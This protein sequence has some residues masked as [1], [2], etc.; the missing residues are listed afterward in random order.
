MLGFTRV[1]RSLALSESGVSHKPTTS[2]RALFLR[3]ARDKKSNIVVVVDFV[4]FFVAVVVHHLY[5]EF[6]IA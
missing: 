5:H 4:I 6:C 1:K 2:K 3:D